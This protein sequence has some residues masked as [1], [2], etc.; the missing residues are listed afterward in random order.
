LKNIY[1]IGFMGSGKS[2]V[3]KLLAEKL[4]YKYIDTDEEIE[5]ETGLKISEIFN[6][7]GEKYFRELE[8]KKIQELA[9]K[10]NLVVSTGGGLPAN[11]NNIQIMK[12]SGKI[13]WLKIDFD[14][15]LSRTEGDSNRP[16]LKENINQLKERFEFRKQ[17][18]SKADLIVDAN[19]PAEQVL[20]EILEN[21]NQH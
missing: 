13:I 20:K 12:N 18:Y 7:F 17:F 16:L 15:F 11:D 2:T 19:K 6:K 10:S 5:K 21:L 3:G 9:K 14:T 8:N 4:G 1:L